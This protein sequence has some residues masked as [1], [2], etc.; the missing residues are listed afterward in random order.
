MDIRVFQDTQAFIDT[1]Q[2]RDQTSVQLREFSEHPERLDSFISM[3]SVD[4][5]V[6]RVFSRQDSEMSQLSLCDRPKMNYFIPSKCINLEIII[7][8]GEFG[9][10]YKGKMNATPIAVKT[11]R[12]EH[13]RK[14]KQEFLR[15]ASVMIK[16]EHKCIVRLYGISK[17]STLMMIQELVPMG[18][19][20]IYIQNNKSQ[21]K[22]N[23]NLKIWASQIAEGEFFLLEKCCLCYC[24]LLLK[25]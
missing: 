3:T 13:T 17:G 21:I 8:E 1:A 16:L 6:G 5:D 22:S 11:L 18:S 12:D 14:N 9:S 20:L 25:E 24:N 10:V 15:E 2:K 7:G 23:G 4:S 19:M